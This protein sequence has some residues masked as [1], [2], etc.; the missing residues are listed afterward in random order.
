[1]PVAPKSKASAAPYLGPLL[2]IGISFLLN[3]TLLFVA[4]AFVGPRYSLPFPAHVIHCQNSLFR[5]VGSKSEEYRP[6]KSGHIANNWC[7]NGRDEVYIEN[8]SGE[9]DNSALKLSYEKAFAED[10]LKELSSHWL[11]AHVIIFI[12]KSEEKF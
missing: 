11:E 1:M 3:C 4:C 6:D 7:I 8:I 5:R 9:E 10:G 12:K 2:Y